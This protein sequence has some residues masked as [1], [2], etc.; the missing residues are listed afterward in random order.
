MTSRVLA[1]LFL[2]ALVTPA[3]AVGSRSLLGTWEAA[4]SPDDE[5]LYVHLKDKGR[6]EIVAEYDFTLPGVPGKRRGRSTTFG[7]WSVSGDDVVITYSKVRD[8][9][10]YSDKLPLAEIGLSGTSAALKATGKT[11]PKSRIRGATLWKAPHEY[12]LKAPEAAPTSG[13]TPET[14]TPGE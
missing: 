9:L 11:D 6:A 2:L 3:D 4:R 5:R 12:K 1:L 7:K 14:G 8:R 10:R 13:T